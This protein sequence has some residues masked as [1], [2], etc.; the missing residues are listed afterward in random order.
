M[1]AQGAV[2][3]LEDGLILARCLKAHA[4][5]ATAFARYEAAR[6]QRTARCVN[7][8][9]ENARRFHN[10]TLANAA[11]AEAYVTREW[12][13]ERVKERYDWLFTYDATTVPV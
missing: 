13:P 8:S 3:A 5:H 4:D 10:P 6:L 11:G 9:A 7:G 12:Q 2:M 1:L